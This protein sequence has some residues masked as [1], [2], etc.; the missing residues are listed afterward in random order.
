[1]SCSIYIDKEAVWHARQTALIGPLHR[2]PINISIRASVSG[3][4]TPRC[5]VRVDEANGMVLQ[6]AIEWPSVNMQRQQSV[7]ALIQAHR[8]SCTKPMQWFAG[9]QVAPRRHPWDEQE[10]SFS[11]RA[12]FDVELDTGAEA[13]LAVRRLSRQGFLISPIHDH[14]LRAKHVFAYGIPK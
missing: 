5:L 8:N 13:Q 7:T 2:R 1:L 4:Q 3:V 11:T 6:Y 10:L 14:S 9:A 12:W